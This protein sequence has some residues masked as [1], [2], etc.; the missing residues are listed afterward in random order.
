MWQQPALV[1]SPSSITVASPMRVSDPCWA[2][3]S[4]S[5]G[6]RPHY[7]T[8]T[9]PRTRASPTPAFPRE[10]GPA[11]APFL[12]ALTNAFDG[13]GHPPARTGTTAPPR[14]Q[15]SRRVR[16]DGCIARMMRKTNR[17]RLTGSGR[18]AALIGRET[19][20]S[21]RT[22]AS[23]HKTRTTASSR[24]CDRRPARDRVGD[25]RCCSRWGCN[26][27]P[28]RKPSCEAIVGAGR[29]PSLLSGVSDRQLPVD[30]AVRMP[31]FR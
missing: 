31:R 10:E 17:A 24:T 23:L 25:P 27:G 30:G 8:S 21:P 13:S 29:H 11:L 6:P 7:A 14:T 5:P 4:S 2:E 19:A 15:E 28:E 20:G 12:Q 26:S 1:G 22:R 3:P 18:A 9:G 16:P